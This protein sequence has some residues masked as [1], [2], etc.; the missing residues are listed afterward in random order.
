MPI[1]RASSVISCFKVAIPYL[2]T[3]KSRNPKHETPNNADIQMPNSAADVFWS[4]WALDSFRILG[5]VLGIFL[6]L[7]YLLAFGF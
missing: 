6:A 7:L 2:L 1:P 4:L 5:L 3:P